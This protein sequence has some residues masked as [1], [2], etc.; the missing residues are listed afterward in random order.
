VLRVAPVAGAPDPRPS[1]DAAWGLHLADVNIALGNLVA[2]VRK[3]AARYAARAAARR[4]RAGPRL[5][6]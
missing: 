2:L 3:Q 1:P 5:T 4:R 6:G